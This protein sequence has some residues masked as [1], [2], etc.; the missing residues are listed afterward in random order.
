MELTAEQRRIVEH[1]GGPARVTGGDGYGR[2]TAMV[3]RYLDL[4]G[5]HG[6]STVLVV[7]PSRGAAG[8]F[9]DAVLPQLSGGFDALPIT[10]WFGVAFDLIRRRG[11][12]VHLLN[13]SEQRATVRHLLAAE[14]PEHWPL[15]APFL[16]R[17]AFADEVA[18]ALLAF[19]AGDAGSPRPSGR[20]AELARFA[21]RY[22]AYLDERA[23]ADRAGLFAAAAD[24]AVPGGYAHVLVDDHDGRDPSL[25]RLLGAVAGPTD[26]VT[27]VARDVV[28]GSLPWPVVELA[29]TRPFRR[30]DEPTLVTCRHPST[31]PEAVAAELWAARAE[32][33]AWSD[34]AVLVR[35]PHVHGRRVARAL[36]R[37]GIPV[38][39]DGGA[40]ARADDPT[41]AALVDLLRWVGEPGDD[42]IVPDRLL[43][44]P[45]AGVGVD[46][47]RSL[48][49]ELA[50]L[51]ETATPAELAFVVWERALGPILTGAGRDD[52][53]LDAVVAFLDRL[54]RDADNDPRSR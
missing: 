17:A 34:M 24:A 54:E 53:A 32:G 1:V 41:V 18:A 46:G 27:V 15:S 30:P 36:S 8:R 5:R 44:S 12:D 42:A 37:H 38:A 50:V 28:G 16:G 48:R 40:G 11:R 49:E 4:V 2:T 39:A 26:D 43:A 13:A 19:Q 7:C 23:Q 25:R 6:A 9:R 33:V 20:W 52:P 22:V 31:E 10:T 45:L 35:R 51:A 47:L 21:E 3:A 14:P 29:L